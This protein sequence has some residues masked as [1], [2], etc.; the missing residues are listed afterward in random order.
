MK[1]AQENISFSSDQPFPGP[2]NPDLFPFFN[3][4][5][6]TLEPDNPARE[7]VLIKSAQLGG[8]VVAQVFLG[9]CQDTDP[10]PFLYVHPT[11][12]NARRWDNTKWSPF[13]QSS[14]ALRQIF[15]S[16][17]SRERKN[18]AYYKER[19]DGRG[20]LLLTGANSP[21][22][23][24]MVT[25]PR[26]IQDD[27]AKW[28][29]NE[30][31][32]PESQADSRS[33]AYEWGA[34]IFKVSTPMVEGACRIT[35][36]YQRSD[37]RV[38]E[39]PCPECGHYHAL[40]WDNLKKSIYE[41]MDPAAAHF[42][43][44]ECGGII[45]HHHKSEMVARGRWK[46]ENPAS[47]VAGFYIWSAYSPLISWARIA[48]EYLKAKDEPEAEQNFYNDIV[49]KAYEMKG[50]AP[51]WKDIRDRA[52]SSDYVAGEIPLGAVLYTYGLD[53]QADRIE[54]ILKGWGPNLRRWTIQQGVIDGHISEDRARAELDALVR[55]KWRNSFGREFMA[56]MLAIDGNYDTNDVMDWAKRWPENKVIVTRGANQH[57]APPLVPVKRERWNSGKIRPNQKR[58]WHVGVSGL[59]ASLFKHLE[60]NDP[61]DRGFCGYPNDLD[62]EYYIQ[63][64]SERRILHK[65]KSGFHELKWVK[66]PGIRNEVLDMEVYAE[67]AA[68]RLGW[69]DSSDDQWES[70][71]QERETPPPD[72]QGDLLDRTVSPMPAKK[73]KTLRVKTKGL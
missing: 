65:L 68:R 32:D 50:D 22:S 5:L 29:N 73:K 17:K 21:S 58:F 63:L 62:D 18:T 43:C 71:M 69:H 24:S 35:R 57:H 66:L 55:R 30:A 31:G 72:G 33:Q 51:P 38:Y 4:V 3:K 7:V 19:V 27:L 14:P 49:G 10:G 8:T 70:L 26:Q 46:A 1:W 23:L 28:E 67:A 61:L 34:K 44:P 42:H 54:W 45:E 60:R 36:A 20:Y 40:E 6:K 56:D 41:G 11:L 16:G 59:K 39:V 53:C 9:A 64:C 48:T 12:D 47:S 15:P 25:M 37:Q 2:Y 13:V 52:R